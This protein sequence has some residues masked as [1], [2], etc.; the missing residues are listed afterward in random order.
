MRSGTT[1]LVALK[2]NRKFTGIELNPKYIEIAERKI[3]P[4]LEQNR[5]Y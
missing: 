3:N 1:A 2:L 5:L 4:E